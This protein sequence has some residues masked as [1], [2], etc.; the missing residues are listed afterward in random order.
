MRASVVSGVSVPVTPAG[1]PVVIHV[2]PDKYKDDD[3]NYLTDE[4]YHTV[5][6]SF[7][8][9]IDDNLTSGN[10]TPKVTKAV[11]TRP[12]PSK[13]PKYV[14]PP[15]PAPERGEHYKVQILATNKNIPLASLPS[16]YRNIDNVVVERYLIDGETSYKY[17]IPVD[18]KEEAFKVQRQMLNRGIDDV[19]IVV[20]FNESRIRPLQ[21]KPN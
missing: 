15:P 9:D 18:S 20:Y 7:D 17:V 16:K 6:L 14:P 12:E 13:E 4:A 2:D 11:L 5:S 3:I 19:W 21:G 1:P 8:V 10:I